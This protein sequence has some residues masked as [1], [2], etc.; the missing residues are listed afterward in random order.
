VNY[1]RVPPNFHAVSCFTRILVS[2]CA[3]SRK[4]MAM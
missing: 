2:F 3:I 4:G 1:L